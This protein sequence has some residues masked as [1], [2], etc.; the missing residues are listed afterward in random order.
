M[1]EEVLD[2]LACIRYNEVRLA[3]APARGNT[4]LKVTTGVIHEKQLLFDLRT[5]SGSVRHPD[6]V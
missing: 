5:V 3:T 6:Q 4:M 1:A 2:A